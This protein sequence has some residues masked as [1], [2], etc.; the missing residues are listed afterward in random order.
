MSIKQAVLVVIHAIVTL[1]TILVVFDACEVDTPDLPTYDR[2]HT[3]QCP[4][5]M[6]C[7]DTVNDIMTR[8]VTCQCGPVARPD[9]GGTK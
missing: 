5:Q 6:V 4:G 1:A 7:S 9:D 3:P 8:V 2:D